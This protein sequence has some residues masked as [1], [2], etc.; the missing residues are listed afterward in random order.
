MRGNNR[1]WQRPAMTAGRPPVPF[2]GQRERMFMITGIGVHDQPDYAFKITGIRTCVH[3]LFRQAWTAVDISCHLDINR[4]RADKWVRLEALPERFQCDPK[5]TSPMRLYAPLQEVMRKGVRE[6]PTQG[7]TAPGRR[8][9]PQ[10][11]ATRG[12]RGL[13][14]PPPKPLKNREVPPLVLIVPIAAVS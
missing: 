13:A 1:Q 12:G 7:K 2:Q 11:A 5:P 6:T 8:S 10:K 3:E 4:R 9:R 14:A